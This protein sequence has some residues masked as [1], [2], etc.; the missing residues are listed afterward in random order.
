[1]MLPSLQCK[2]PLTKD[3]VVSGPS[4]LFETSV[5][6]PLAILT[7][8][9]LLCCCLALLSRDDGA[10]PLGCCRPRQFCVHVLAS[11]HGSTGTKGPIGGS[12]FD[13]RECGN[14]VTDRHRKERSE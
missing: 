6:G 3:F 4:R 8:T 14:A 5:Q 2:L 12:D 10:R 9:G 7:V 1:M 13:A 11:R